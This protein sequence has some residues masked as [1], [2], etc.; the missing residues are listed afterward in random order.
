MCDNKHTYTHTHTHTRMYVYIRAYIRLTRMCVC[1]C[2][3]VCVHTHPLPTERV[4]YQA[5][6]T[7]EQ[8]PLGRLFFRQ[9]ARPWG[10]HECQTRTTYTSK[11]TYASVTKI[12]TKDLQTQVCL[13]SARVCQTIKGT[14]A[15]GHR[16]CDKGIL[17]TRPYYCFLVSFIVGTYADGI[18]GVCTRRHVAACIHFWR[19]R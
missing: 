13:E 14:D 6:Q 5:P 10:P 15:D 1:V 19:H 12:W 7:T 3:C 8:P 11:E 16:Q 9:W 2:V 18:G 17:C 4:L